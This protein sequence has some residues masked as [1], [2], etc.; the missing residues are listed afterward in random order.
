MTEIN[1]KMELSKSLLVV[2]LI[3]LHLRRSTSQNRLFLKRYLA[4]KYNLNHFTFPKDMIDVP[5]YSLDR[6]IRTAARMYSHMAGPLPDGSFLIGQTRAGPICFD[7]N[8]S[9]PNMVVIDESSTGLG[10]RL[11][12]FMLDSANYYAEQANCYHAGFGFQ[13]DGFAGYG[14]INPTLAHGYAYHS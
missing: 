3:S 5:L 13:V 11:V 1:N 12:Q 8:D 6:G 9:N 7:P 14:S 2:Y 4:V 10:M